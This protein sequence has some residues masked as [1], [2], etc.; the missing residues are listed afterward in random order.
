MSSA[1]LEEAVYA[2]TR[3]AIGDAPL[4]S[5]ALTRAI[6]DRS[7]RYTSDRARLAAP[8]DKVGDLAARA[9][10]FTIADAMKIA[11]PFAEL[12]GR[13]ALPATRPLRVTDLGAGCGAM[14]LGLIASTTEPLTILAI[15]RD[16]PALAIAAAAVKDFARRRGARVEITTRVDDA[17]K[18][19][20]PA[21]DLIVIGTLLNELDP[22]A[23][24]AIVE[25]ALAAIAPDGAVII[26]EPALRETS[27]A[28]HELRDVI[29]GRGAA[30]V[31]APCTRGIA[32]CPALAD[33]SDWCHE[34]RTL[35]LP[36]RTAELARLTHL[37]DGGMKFSY[38]VLRHDARTL[39][40]EPE[41]W[42]IV[43]APRS[44]KGKLEVIGCSAAG[45][46]PLRLLR[47]N[48][49]DHNRDIERA[50][51]G[52]VVIVSAPPGDERVEIEADT[53]VERRKPAG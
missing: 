49:G 53:R 47:R 44:Q 31:F 20:L 29:L 48:R 33:P 27:R 37:R 36:R 3:A 40:D 22:A 46:I 4:A 19:K 23:R 30:H 39:V 41:A 51:R 15:D 18:A 10:F 52:D 9:A 8:V 38:L 13:G 17:T 45:R 16:Q 43:S 35:A 6:V 25:R 1:E 26:I 2:A 28:L 7:E 42:R 12:A 14:S 11:I 50:E 34:H 5:S 32:P 24:L 21:S